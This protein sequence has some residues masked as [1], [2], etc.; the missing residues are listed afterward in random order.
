M[1]EAVP[2]FARLDEA[3]KLKEV[4]DDIFKPLEEVEDEK[5]P[6]ISIDDF[7]KVELK[8]GVVLESANVEGAKK[9]LV[10]K[11]KIG[12]EVRQ[13]VSGIAEYYKPEELVGKKVVVVTN[14]KPVKLRGVLS[15]GMILCASKGKKLCIVTPD[16]DI[17]DGAEVR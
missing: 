10:S 15:E 14:L 5:T 1:G 12:N 13:I 4:E 6:E 11:I 16:G 3:K 9:L 17:D 8:T 7:A 2:L